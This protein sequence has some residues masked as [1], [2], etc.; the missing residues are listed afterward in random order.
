MPD[1][2]CENWDKLNRAFGRRTKWM[3]SVGRGRV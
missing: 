1:P 3:H 2:F